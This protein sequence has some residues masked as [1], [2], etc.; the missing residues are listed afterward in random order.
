MAKKEKKKSADKY[1]NTMVDGS[2]I[3]NAQKKLFELAHILI[4]CDDLGA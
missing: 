4:I 2:Q 3:H 1:D